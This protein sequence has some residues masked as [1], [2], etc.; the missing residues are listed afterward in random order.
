L[1]AASGALCLLPAM[2]SAQ[3]QAG[4]WELTLVGSG[5]SSK[6][7]NAATMAGTAGIGYFFTKNAEVALRQSIGYVDADHTLTNGDRAAGGTTW[8]GASY[9]AFDWH[10]DLDQ[11]QP[12]LGVNVGAS[13]GTGKPVWNAGLEGGVK[14]YLHRHAFVFGQVAYEFD[15]QGKAGDGQVL[16]SLGIGTNW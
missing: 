1:G 12:F 9:G 6:K 5:I 13:Y 2:A 16:Y 15:L 10:F 8:T 7:L 14:Y 11:W 4:D 3:P